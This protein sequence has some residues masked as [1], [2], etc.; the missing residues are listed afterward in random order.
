MWIR[1]AFSSFSAGSQCPA[2][3]RTRALKT[4]ADL[5]L[6]HRDS[7]DHLLIAQSISEDMIFMTADGMHRSIPHES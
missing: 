1:T 6:H 2:G 4:L 3:H 5:P 7:I